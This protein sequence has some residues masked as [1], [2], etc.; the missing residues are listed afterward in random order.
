MEQSVKT[1]ENLKFYFFPR[2]MSQLQLANGY[3]IRW[4]QHVN[5]AVEVDKIC[6]SYTNCLPF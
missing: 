6:V 2:K 5:A 4:K 1:Q 3:L